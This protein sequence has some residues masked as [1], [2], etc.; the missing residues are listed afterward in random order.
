MT[1]R[2]VDGASSPASSPS[3]VDF[4]L[5]EGPVIAT[6][7]PG[8]DAQIQRMQDRE[9]RVAARD[10]LG[11]AVQFDHEAGSRVD[12]RPQHVPDG[13]GDDLGALDVGMDAVRLVER[14]LARDLVEQEREERD[15]VLSGEIAIHLPERY[16][17]F[18]TEVRRRFHAREQD[19]DAFF[20]RAL[21]DRGEVLLHLRHR[22]A[23]KAV[24]GAELQDQDADVP[25]AERPLDPLQPR[26]RRVA[27][28]AGVDDFPLVAVD[29]ELLLEQRRKRLQ[30]EEPV[31][32]GQAVA[33]H[34]DLRAS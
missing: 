14:R 13:V 19:G 10:C 31:A 23:A 26:G 15:V 34:D 12:H 16:G 18:R 6:T 5:P 20:L 2:P 4:P 8:L 33:E 32:G 27:G 11:N 22:Q 28:D 9:H 17:V 24:V 29:V 30:L 21:D 3:S 1:M 7:P 25:L